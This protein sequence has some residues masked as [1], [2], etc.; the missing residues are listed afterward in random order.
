M[1]AT[2]KAFICSTANWQLVYTQRILGA[3]NQ[4]ARRRR[5]YFLLRFFVAFS[6]RPG[7][8]QGEDKKV[9]A[10]N[11]LRPAARQKMNLLLN[12]KIKEKKKGKRIKNTL[13][14]DEI[15]PY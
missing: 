2:P 13:V 6:K 11:S 4:A 8:R 15:K 5:I 14:A 1:E 10:N 3:V 7:R 12:K 9:L